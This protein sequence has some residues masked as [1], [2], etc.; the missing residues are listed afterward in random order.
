MPLTNEDRALIAAWRDLRTA[1]EVAI[2]AG[3]EDVPLAPLL[4]RAKESFAAALHAV[5]REHRRALQWDA[6]GRL[7]PEKQ[8]SARHRAAWS[9]SHPDECLSR[10]GCTRDGD[11]VVW[12]DGERYLAGPEKPRYAGD[13]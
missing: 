5:Q 11:E 10:E 2:F 3:T 7:P 8:A 4:D 12:P 1:E 13:I 6:I 9:H